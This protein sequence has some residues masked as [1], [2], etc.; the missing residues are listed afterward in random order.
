M[1][2]WIDNDVIVYVWFIYSQIK[3]VWKICDVNKNNSKW[4]KFII[5]KLKQLRLNPRLSLL[6]SRTLVLSI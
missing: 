6:H 4:T 2:T 3:K 1:E 5:K